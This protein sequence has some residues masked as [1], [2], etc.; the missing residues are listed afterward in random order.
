MSDALFS[1]S[2][3]RVSGLKPRIRA[4]VRILR[5]TFR[6]QVWFVLQDD[7]AERAHRFT[8]AAHHV[9]GLMD[10]RRSVQQVW[11]AA[12]SSLGDAAPTQED[13]IRL[14]AQLHAADALLADVPSDS[15]EV[16]RR[17]QKHQRM[18]WK[19]RLWSPLS[20]RFPLIDPDRFLQRTLPWV[21]PLFGWFGLALWLLVVGSAAVLATAH[22]TDLS[23]NLVDRV[24]APANLVLLWLV[25]PVVKSLHELGHAYATRHWGG[26]VH[27]IGVMLLVLTPVPYV[28]A[29]AATGFKSK[30]QRMV[31]GAAGIAVE[32]FLGSLALFVWLIVE[33]G[34]VSSVAYNVMLISGVSTL[35]FNGNPLLRF[36]GYYVLSDAI[37]IP[38]L[39]A[40]SNQY[41][42]YLVQRHLLGA[43]DV[44]SPAHTT[45]ERIW[46]VGYGI[47]S[48]IYRIFIMVVIITFIAS[49]FF[50][51][52]LL[53][54]AWA[55]ATQVVMPVGK[56]LQS[57]LNSPHLRRQRGRSAAIG[58]G[59]A[60][61]LA[62]LLF[63]VPA[64]LWTRAEGV[65][66]VPDEAQV[67]ADTDGF[68]ERLLA[69]A[70]A[71]VTAGQPLLRLDDPFLLTRVAVLQ[72]QQR[73]LEAQH[74]ALAFTDRVQAALVAEELA[75]V[76]ANLR[77]ALQREA[78]LLLRSPAAGRWVVP[79][80]ADL[81]GR[82]VSQGQL[83]GYLVRPQDFSARVVLLQDDIALVRERTRAVEVVLPGWGSQPLTARIWREVP[84]GATQLPT[85]AL[86]SNGG[87]MLAVDPRDAQ[88]TTTLNR[89]FQLELRL[90]QEAYTP[91]LGARVQVR[92]DLGHQP[93]GIQ[94]YN[95]VRRL[96]LRQFDV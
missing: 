85:A 45:G 7:A 10:G 72:A 50:V 93:V 55:V 22:W 64:P 82:H 90:P 71:L 49:R 77:R 36:D 37:E 41:L 52:G 12:S 94:V 65:V 54:A 70:D 62:L 38:N 91:Y 30:Y 48:F 23:E 29:S 4:H 26:E 6:N 21:A 74:Q 18:K 8:P 13:V 2:W 87:G 28:D 79:Q 44:P 61:G 27:E 68:V 81:P 1:P 51:V 24:L 66:W 80:A 89:V 42:G 96:L 43:R 46:M 31:V 5:Q 84:G 88:G 11:E 40:R 34:I 57:M 60:A 25:Y 59:V 19:R 78:A 53:L 58:L 95:A 69:P 76:Q 67:R 75:T 9:I 33:P 20:L 15:M 92:F 83:I 47:T 3:Y 39:G 16:F 56:S 32:L 17:H 86:G 73:E 14:L 63:A 35:L